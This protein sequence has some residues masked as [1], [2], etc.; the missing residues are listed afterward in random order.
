[1]AKGAIGVPYT[2]YKGAKRIDEEGRLLDIDTTGLKMTSH[3]RTIL[4]PNPPQSHHHHLQT[5][6]QPPRSST[7]TNWTTT[8]TSSSS[9]ET[10]PSAPAQRAPKHRNSI[11]HDLARGTTRSL[12]K[13]ARA[14]ARAPLDVSLAVA[15]GFHNAPRLYGDATVRR[16]PRVTGLHSGLR[17]AGKEFALGMYDGLAGVVSQ[18]YY[19]AR[20]NG[21]AGDR[22]S[23]FA[24]GLAR[25]LGG[26][27][28]KTNAAAAGLLAYS[29]KGVHKELR[30]ERDRRWARLIVR[31]RLVQGQRDYHRLREADEL[32]VRDAAERRARI[33]E[34]EEEEGQSESEKIEQ[35]REE[36]EEGESGL[37]SL[38]RSCE[39]GWTQVLRERAQRRQDEKLAN[40]VR[41]IRP[42]HLHHHGHK[43]HERD[44]VGRVLEHVEDRHNACEIKDRIETAKEERRIQKDEEGK[45]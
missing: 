3:R 43:H 1:M 6:S 28:L 19:G 2:W 5:Q 13:L 7:D 31:A 37:R 36:E 18:P 12:S 21:D 25:G 14:G 16:P 17:A 39:Q 20:A 45:A 41:N 4:K 26:V 35:K 22:V 30:K 34:E 40:R 11:R 33:V 42:H 44:E 9:P 23:G 27:V 8:P 38:E 15:Q 29:L 24:K 10:S 32:R